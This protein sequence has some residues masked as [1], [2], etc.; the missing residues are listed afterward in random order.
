MKKVFGK[1][2]VQNGEPTIVRSNSVY[3]RLG[4]FPQ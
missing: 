3:E 4:S 1:N 2:V